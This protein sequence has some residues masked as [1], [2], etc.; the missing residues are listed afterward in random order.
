M[1]S[2]IVEPEF[3]RMSRTEQVRHT[4]FCPVVE[5]LHLV[6]NEKKFDDSQV[7]L[8]KTNAIQPTTQ[9]R[10]GL[11]DTLKGAEEHGSARPRKPSG[12][13]HPTLLGRILSYR[14][15]KGT[16]TRDRLAS[17]LGGK[18]GGTTFGTIKFNRKRELVSALT[19]TL[20]FSA[21]LSLVRPTSFFPCSE[22]G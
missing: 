12:N 13:Q 9:S 14:K 3:F 5:S 8:G 22:T 1:T 10:I 6:G 15:R 2:E 17:H 19:I 16:Q 11:E 20:L 18:M 4:D 21:L 7:S